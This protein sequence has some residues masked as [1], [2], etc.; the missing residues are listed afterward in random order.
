M[1]IHTIKFS[2]FG[3]LGYFQLFTFTKKEP[4]SEPE[5]TFSKSHWVSLFLAPKLMAKQTSTPSSWQSLMLLL[6]PVLS[7]PEC[8]FGIT[9]SVAFSDWLL[10]LVGG[11]G[12]FR[13]SPW[14]PKSTCPSPLCK[15]DE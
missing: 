14:V 9:Q 3:L 1:K 13:T 12:G 7:F 4:D 5:D 15:T 6:S 8:H 11:A 10:L 2:R